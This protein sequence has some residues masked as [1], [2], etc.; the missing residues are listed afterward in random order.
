[1]LARKEYKEFDLERKTR[2]NLSKMETTNY[3]NYIYPF[4]G[5]NE[6]A[7]SIEKVMK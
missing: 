5:R 1:M 3:Y 7:V 4:F 2:T 6:P